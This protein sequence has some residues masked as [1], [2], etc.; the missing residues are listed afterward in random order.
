MIRVS[1]SASRHSRI[2]F[3]IISNKWDYASKDLARDM[4]DLRSGRIAHHLPNVL[5][6]NMR[7]DEPELLVDLTRDLGENVGRVLVT[8]I[9]R[10]IDSLSNHLAKIGECRR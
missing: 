7:L 2:S 6:L 5:S 10:L 3:S 4:R 8:E 9:S 1:T